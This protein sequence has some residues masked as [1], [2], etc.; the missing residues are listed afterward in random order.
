MNVM[1][2]NAEQATVLTRAPA[3]AGPL[4]T[5]LPPGAPAAV[6]LTNPPPR[7]SLP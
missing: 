2:R 4:A 1:Q 5:R 6:H 3:V 7:F